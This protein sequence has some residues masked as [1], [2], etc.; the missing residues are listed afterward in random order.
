MANINFYGDINLKNNILKE[1]K[2]YNNLGQLTSSG[3]I[4]NSFIS[5]E[6]LE[7]GYYLIHLDNNSYKFIKK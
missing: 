2:V 6:N 5:I 4:E 1:F 7:I 3:I